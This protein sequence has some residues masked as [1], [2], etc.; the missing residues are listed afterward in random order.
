MAKHK[1]HLKCVL[2]LLAMHQLYAN[3]NKCQFGQ[4]K[5]E[6]LGHVISHEGVATDDSKI[7]AVMEWPSPKSLRELRGFLGLTRYYRRFV[8]N[9]GKLAWPFTFGRGIFFG[10]N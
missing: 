3:A 6:Y 10:M 2:G 9:Y 1:E 8:K 4:Q 5:I 7:K